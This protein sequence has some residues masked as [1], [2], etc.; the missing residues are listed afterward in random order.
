M[1]LFSSALQDRLWTEWLKQP[2]PN[3]T[4][5]HNENFDDEAWLNSM[6]SFYRA[7]GVLET[8]RVRD[9]LDPANM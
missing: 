6:Y 3:T 2:N 1:N 9:T 8:I 4:S 7:D 5:G